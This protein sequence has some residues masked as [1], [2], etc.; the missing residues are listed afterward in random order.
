MNTPRPKVAEP[1][2]RNSA[3][4][5]ERGVLRAPALPAGRPRPSAARPCRTTRSGCPREAAATRAV[6]H[7]RGA[8]G[9]RLRER[10]PQPRFKPVRN[11]SSTTLSVASRRRDPARGF[12]P[13]DLP[14]PSDRRAP[15]RR[16]QRPAC[17]PS[18][19]QGPSRRRRLRSWRSRSRRRRSRGGRRR[20]ARSRANNA[21]YLS[22][23]HSRTSR[24]SSV[25]AP[26]QA[27]GDP[28]DLR[29]AARRRVLLALIRTAGAAPASAILGTWRTSLWSRSA[30]ATACRTR[31]SCCRPMRR[32][33]DRRNWSR[34]GRAGSRRSSSRTPSSSRRWP[35]PRT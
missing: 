1:G 8:D 32:S 33:T 30:R 19:V 14:G 31:R 35:T 12:R 13:D 23:P 21:A 7:Q 29:R 2:P 28:G 6:R 26:A 27:V 3:H 15:S 18:V 22:A 4:A 11:C 17:R 25:S 9:S 5:Q 24:P 10:A 34:L 20:G 16:R